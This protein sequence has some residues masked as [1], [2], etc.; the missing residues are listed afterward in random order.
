VASFSSIRASHEPSGIER[1]AQRRQARHRP[2]DQQPPDIG[3]AGLR[4]PAEPFLA[5]GGS[6]AGARPSQ[7][8][9]SRP[10]RNCSI[11]G[12]KASTASAVI[13]PTPGIVCRR[14]AVSV[15]LASALIRL[16]RASMRAVFSAICASRSRHS[17]QT[18]AGRSLW[19]HRG[20]PRCA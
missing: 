15:S 19:G 1:R 16:V 13:G 5:A 20:S 7:A 14:R 8:A 6:L 10:R 18:S 4:D 17:S 12:A 11:S 9:K 2:D 3:L